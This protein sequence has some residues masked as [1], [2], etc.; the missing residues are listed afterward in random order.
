MR[1]QA[2]FAPPQI[3]VPRCFPW[4]E[5][6]ALVTAWFLAFCAGAA[7]T[8]PRGG[9]GKHMASPARGTRFSAVL[10]RSRGALC[11]AG[12]LA[13][14]VACSSTPPQAKPVA[15]SSGVPA[16]YTEF[17]DSARGYSL[18]VPSSWVQINVQSGAAAA[19]F[20]QLLK[21]K[22]QFTQVFGNN[23]ATLE[24]ENLSLL[25]VGPNG[26]SANMVVEQGSGTLT[27][28][29][30]G[31]VYSTELQP[32]YQRAGIKLLGHGAAR[33]DGY[34]ALRTSIVFT[35]GTA[36]RPETQFIAGVHGRI[37]ILTVALASAT[38]ADEIAGTVRFS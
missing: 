18:A 21:E 31:T 15:H 26:T 28:A 27:A 9:K 6:L 16:G 19:E 8:V 10:V 37:Y 23:L 33:L 29:Q 24:K 38:L 22:P 2:G 17:R 5:R 11:A 20:A 14:L 32:S 1:C 36:A 25:A 12:L 4:Y 34:P 35:I 3:V 7:P 13:L 30:L